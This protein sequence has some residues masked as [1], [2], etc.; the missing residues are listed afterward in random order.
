MIEQLTA[1]ADGR[2]GQPRGVG[3]RVECAGAA[4][5]QCR[6]DLFRAG[7]LLAGLTGEQLYGRTATLPLFFTTAQVGLATGVMR[8]VQRTF[9]AQLAIDVV[10]VH[11]AEH[12]GRRRPQHAVELA[13]NRLA[14]PGFDLVRGNPHP[15]IDQPDVAPGTTMTGAMGLQHANSLALLQQMHRRRQT[16]KPG[17]D[18]ADIHRDLTLEGRIVRPLRRQFFPQ[19]LFA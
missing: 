7:G 4:I 15:G 6:G 1:Q 13:A 19:T 9:A 17:A 8:H 14:K 5:E 16:G 3:H 2:F 11:K 18:D 12:Q 10:L